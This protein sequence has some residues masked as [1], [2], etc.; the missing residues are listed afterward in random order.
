MYDNL[1]TNGPSHSLEY[2]DYTFDEHFGKPVTVY[3]KRQD[4]L[5]YVLG[6]V[7]KHCP[8]FF[9]KYV[10]FE[11]EVVR[12]V[13]D[14]SKQMFDINVKDLRSGKITTH[15]FHKCVWACGE[16]AKPKIPQ[17]LISMFRN[18]G[19]KGRMIH[20][21]D[22]AQFEEDVRGKRVLLIGGGFSAEDL[23]LQA[24]KCGVDKIYCATRDSEGG[25]IAQNESW[26]MDK[27]EILK[28][29]SPIG[30]TEDGRCI[31]FEYLKEKSWSGDYG[32]Y[33]KKDGKTVIRN[34]DTIIFCT[35]YDINFGMLDEPLR[36]GHPEGYGSPELKIHE[37]WRMQPNK[38]T[39]L[40]GHVKPGKTEYI[41]YNVHPALYRGVLVSG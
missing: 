40:L 32:E 5:E 8:N 1:W 6:R 17:D 16:N 9:E 2:F 38:L 33:E 3:L 34:I 26:P 30:V 28:G 22:T 39:K 18:G 29:R 7:T 41:Q 31:E 23:A 12:V 36:Q 19:F 37:D 20:S 4:L 35:G 10:R 21:S 13:Y 25:H 27:V 15:E 11:T 14:E 24:I